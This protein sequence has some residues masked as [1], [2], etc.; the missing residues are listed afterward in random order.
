MYTNNI[1]EKGR[2]WKVKVV[3][4]REWVKG[5]ATK[6]ED[7]ALEIELIKELIPLGLKA[8]EEILV[9]EVDEI[10][11]LWYKRFPGKN[12]YR[13]GKQWGSVYLHDQKVPILVPRVRLKGRMREGEISLKTYNEFQKPHGLD[14]QAMLRLLNGISTHKY[15][16]SVELVPQVFGISASN[17]SRRFTK[18]A[19]E[20]LK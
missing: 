15:R 9:R 11:G 4:K 5:L 8:V 17:M 16:E 19:E 7:K 6:W 10:A 20:A 13:W 2:K 1:Q 3:E 12:I 18:K 14:R